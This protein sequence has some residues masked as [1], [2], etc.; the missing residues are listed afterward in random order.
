MCQLSGE[1][2][3]TLDENIVSFISEC[4]TREHHESYLIA[5]LHKVQNRYGYLSREHLDEVAQL[6]QVPTSTV[7]GVATFYHYFRLKP[8]GK[9]A[10]SVC[11]GTACFVK[12]ADKILE[13]LRS[14]LGIEIG[15]TSSD[16]LFSLEESRCLGVCAMA[17]VVTINNRI[18]GNV[19]PK[20]V[21]EVLNR[22]REAEEEKE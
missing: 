2:A 13:A 22:M 11:L 12:G 1:H 10:I 8:R 19:S 18:Y 9:Y 4:R 21:P 14:E 17:P 16:G 6:L 20:Q 5:V 7:S 3:H 15:E